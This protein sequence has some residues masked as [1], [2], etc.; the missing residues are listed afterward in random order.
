MPNPEDMANGSDMLFA[1]ALEHV[2][3]VSEEYFQSPRFVDGAYFHAPYV[4]SPRQ[5]TTDSRQFGVVVENSFGGNDWPYY[6]HPISY[7]VA[8]EL[9]AALHADH[10]EADFWPGHRR[11]MERGAAE[12]IIAKRMRNIL[13][14]GLGFTDAR[15]DGLRR[16]E[17]QFVSVTSRKI[18]R[19]WGERH[20][21]WTWHLHEKQSLEPVLMEHGYIFQGIGE[22]GLAHIDLPQQVIAYTP[23]IPTQKGWETLVEMLEGGQVRHVI[24]SAASLQQVVT[25]NGDTVPFAT[26]FDFSY[27]ITKPPPGGPPTGQWEWRSVRWRQGEA[28]KPQ[29]IELEGP[30]YQPASNDGD[31]YQTVATV[32]NRPVLV[33]RQVGQGTLSVLLFD[34]SLKANA[35]LA[36]LLLEDLLSDAGTERQWISADG[37]V[38]RLYRSDAD[39]RMTVVGL[40]SA[41]VRSHRNWFELQVRLHGPEEY[42]PHAHPGRTSAMVRL[43]PGRQYAYVTMPS[44]QRGR[45]TTGEDGMAELSFE[46][47]AW[48]MVYIMPDDDAGHAALE[49][50]AARRQTFDKALSLEPVPAE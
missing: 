16:F 48:E 23:T 17:P 35:R 14:Y 9:T 2:H 46:G 19:P 27:G 49:V 28:R 44:A 6:D 34:P 47:T 37:S 7:L 13:A 50:I 10:L 29:F 39:E 24:T 22:E 31:R 45:T 38:A 32:G 1:S 18:A 43:E 42:L 26:P 11:T 30:M 36:T 3:A 4:F 15:S 5:G 20:N 40:Q 33:Q 41:Q 8:L 12:P 25:R 21:P